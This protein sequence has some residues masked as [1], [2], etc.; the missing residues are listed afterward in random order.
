MGFTADNTCPPRSVYHL[1]SERPD[2]QDST[3]DVQ[4][5]GMDFFA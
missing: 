5:S 4:P 2:L 3:H 1:E